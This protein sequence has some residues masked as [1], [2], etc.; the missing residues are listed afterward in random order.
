MLKRHLHSNGLYQLVYLTELWE[1]CSDTRLH[2]SSR[3]NLSVPRNNL[4]LS[5]KAFSI[6][7]PWA[8]NSVPTDV[9][10]TV[11]VKT[12]YGHL[13]E[14][15]WVLSIDFI[16]LLVWCQW[17]PVTGTLTNVI[18]DWSTDLSEYKNQA[19]ILFAYVRISHGSKYRNCPRSNAGRLECPQ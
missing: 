2:S 3:G 7:G 1:R 5:D 10:S 14:F 16:R 8:L 4:H 12:S 11:T 9:H 15:H 13:S 18:I 17:S 19:D 6:T